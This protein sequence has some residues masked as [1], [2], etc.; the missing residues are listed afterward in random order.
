MLKKKEK[1]KVAKRK[2]QKQI[3]VLHVYVDD[4][5]AV[6]AYVMLHMYML[7]QDGSG[8]V[9]LKV[10]SLKMSTSFDF[11]D[12]A[13]SPESSG[14]EGEEICFCSVELQWVSLTSTG[15]CT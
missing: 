9:R 12:A 11:A 6:V 4:V 2:G 8:E 3:G 15:V 13:D 5:D 1:K 7:L 14:G 10:Q